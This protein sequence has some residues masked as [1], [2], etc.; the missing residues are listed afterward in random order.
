M[1]IIFLM[2][3]FFAGVGQTALQNSFTYSPGG[4]SDGNNTAQFVASGVTGA[5]ANYVYDNLQLTRITYLPSEITSVIRLNGQLSNAELLPSEQLGAGG[6]D[7][8][9]GYDPRAASASQGI[10][11]SLELRSPTYS[12]LKQLDIG[13][14]DNGQLLVFYDSGFIAYLHD[15][16]G[17]AKSASLQSVGFGARYS[18][19]R[20]FDVKFD[21][22][23][24][25]AKAPSASSMGHLA[26]LSVT[27]AY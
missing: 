9:R 12:P 14:E 4:W 19:G 6:T 15:Q 21:Y 16:T 22:G 27:L 24:Q 7:S 2:F 20:Y 5:K 10:L 25:L 18:I 3:H 11:A 1:M 17:V 26:T 8:V 13:I 23:W